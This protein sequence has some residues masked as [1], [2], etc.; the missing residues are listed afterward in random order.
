METLVCP[1]LQT[2]LT[3]DMCQG[4]CACA[5]SAMLHG[6]ETWGPKKRELW[7]LHWNDR[8]MIHWICGIKDRDKTLSGLLTRET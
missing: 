8:A 1:K 5:R 7:Q 4:V 6:S 2:P 3:Q